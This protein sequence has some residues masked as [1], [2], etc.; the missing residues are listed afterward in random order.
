MTEPL[1]AYFFIGRRHV[2]GALW[3]RILR[4]GRPQPK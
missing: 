1:T 3:N 4:I 2:G